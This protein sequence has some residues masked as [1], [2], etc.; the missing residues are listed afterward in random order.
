MSEEKT[1]LVIGR[2][3]KGRLDW[4]MLHLP[5]GVEKDA[6]NPGKCD[7]LQIMLFDAL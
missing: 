5:H 1:S 7:F 3:Y 4:S 6:A 2:G